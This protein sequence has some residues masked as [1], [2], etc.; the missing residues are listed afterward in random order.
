MVIAMAS[1]TAA[2]RDLLFD[3]ILPPVFARIHSIDTGHKFVGLIAA[4]SEL[5]GRNPAITVGIE[6]LEAGGDIG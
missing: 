1:K 3:M 4:A 6:P 5:A 2:K